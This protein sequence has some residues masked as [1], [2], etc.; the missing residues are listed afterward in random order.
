MEKEIQNSR[1][2]RNEKLSNHRILLGGTYI[3][4]EGD[5]HTRCLWIM[6]V[7]WFTPMINDDNDDD[8]DD[9]GDDGND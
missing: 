9:D 8:D 5:K 3:E 6:N 2:L 7:F 4:M 1:D